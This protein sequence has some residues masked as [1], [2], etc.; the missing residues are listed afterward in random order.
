[1]LLVGIDGK[2]RFTL[3]AFQTDVS[4]SSQVSLFPS[5]GLQPA[6][7]DAGASKPD[8]RAT[9]PSSAVN[10]LVEIYTD[11]GCVPN[12]GPGG[13]G[14]VLICDGHE[15][16]LLGY[17]PD[18]TNNRM[19]LLAAIRALEALKF[20]CRVKLHSDSALLINAFTKNWV[21]GWQRKGWVN[22]SKEPVKNRD[23]WERLVELSK[24]HQVEWIK[25]KGH[26]GIH[27]NER[28]DQLATQ[29]IQEGNKR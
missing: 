24:T 29:A 12:P 5:A 6:G 11:G 20:S 25:V 1:M 26:A 23:L 3:D 16:E 19:E 14:A 22:A 17:E 7:T 18:T 27:Y 15:K 10:K 8:L 21:P 28:C 4:Q 9:K 2:W 13:W